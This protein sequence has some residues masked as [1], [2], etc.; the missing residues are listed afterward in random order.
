MGGLGHM[1]IPLLADMTK[2]I[3]TAYGALIK[4]E[5]HP[6]RASYI[7]NPEGIVKYISKQNNDVGRSVDETLR[8]LKAYQFAAEHGEV[9][10]SFSTQ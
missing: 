5:G 9:C 1:K 4:D 3:A 7:I 8:L 6:L 2:N 10:S